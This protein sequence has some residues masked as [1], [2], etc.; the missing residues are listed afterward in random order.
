MIYFCSDPISVDP[1]CPQ[2]KDFR[3]CYAQGLELLNLEG[4]PRV[5]RPQ[6]IKAGKISVETL[7]ARPIRITRTRCTKI[8]EDLGYPGFLI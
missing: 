1:I 5:L 3:T 7:A 8:F 6:K 4:A 2:P